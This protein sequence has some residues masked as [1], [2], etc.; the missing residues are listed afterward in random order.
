MRKEVIKSLIAI[1]YYHKC[2][3]PLVAHKYIYIV[4]DTKL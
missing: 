4:L 1:V 2:S 3:F